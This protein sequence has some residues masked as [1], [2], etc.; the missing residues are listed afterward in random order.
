MSPCKGEPAF[1]MISDV[2]LED[3]GADNVFALAIV[4]KG[5][6][7]SSSLAPIGGRSETTTRDASTADI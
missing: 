4:R 2:I 6:N 5:Q 3:F 7:C 1:Y